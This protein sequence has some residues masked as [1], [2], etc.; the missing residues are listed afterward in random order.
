[1]WDRTTVMSHLRLRCNW[2]LVVHMYC[3]CVQLSVWAWELAPKKLTGILLGRTHR[4]SSDIIA[5]SHIPAHFSQSLKNLG[6]KVWVGSYYTP[7]NISF[8]LIWNSEQ[9]K[10]RL[11]TVYICWMLEGKSRNMPTEQSSQ[12][13]QFT[14]RH[15]CPLTALHCKCHPS[16]NVNCCI[17][18]VL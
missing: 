7:K 16:V 9:Y 3:R 11:K 2:M 15:R 4:A 6:W 18:E 8:W 1:M 13:H 10:K 14:E 17:A 5:L 12:S